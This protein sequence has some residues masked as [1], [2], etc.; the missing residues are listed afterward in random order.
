MVQIDGSKAT[1]E[2]KIKEKKSMK[3]KKNSERNKNQGEKNL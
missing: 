3:R 2:T 1:R